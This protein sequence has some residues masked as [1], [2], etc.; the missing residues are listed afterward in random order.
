MKKAVL[1]FFIF[2]TANFPLFGEHKS[3]AGCL[4]LMAAVD[5]MT[6]TAKSDGSTYLKLIEL[7]EA[8]LEP[9]FFEASF[10]AE[11]PLNPMDGWVKQLS[12]Q[13][14]SA[15]R[16]AFESLFSEK[17]LRDLAFIWPELR[18]RLREVSEKRDD[19]ANTKAQISEKT[20]SIYTPLVV[21]EMKLPSG[22][23]IDFWEF[24]PARMRNGRIF[25]PL[26]VADSNAGSKDMRGFKIMDLDSG[27]R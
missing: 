6:E 5:R 10:K 19:T 20:K 22:T 14:T 11:R 12:P 27:K 18:Q 17:N 1:F 9:G 21:R 23:E 25:L 3:H 2:L 26:R 4:E 8:K 16:R 7:L 15:L 24:E 13:E